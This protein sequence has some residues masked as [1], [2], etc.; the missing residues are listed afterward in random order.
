MGTFLPKT[1]EID[2]ALRIPRMEQRPIVSL[3]FAPQSESTEVR[4][5]GNRVS[6]ATEDVGPCLF[7]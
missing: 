4:N 2:V 3:A 6:T 5:R 1:R 7:F